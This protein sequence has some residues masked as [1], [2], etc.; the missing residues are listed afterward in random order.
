VGK[1][2]LE[3][4]IARYTD[5]HPSSQDTFT[6][7]W[8]PFYLNRDAPR[9]GVDKREYYV[10]RFGEQRSQMMFQRLAEVGRQEGIN[11]KFGGKTGNTR[12]S[13]RLIQLAKL[14]G[15]ETQ[16]RVVDRLFK[17]YFEEE[18]DITSHD[19][20]V[21]A[22][23]EAG[24]DEN[25]V[26]D[27]MKSDK[28]GPEVDREVLQAQSKFISGVPHFT[29]RGKYHLEGAQDPEAFLEIFNKEQL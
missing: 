8:L 1:R 19:V 14:K 10:K 22:G 4:A 11:F 21:K 15:P 16:D 24:L 2:R 18:Q 7:T 25:T 23:V 5:S 6:T 9:K 17:A 13:H 12:D 29:I 3:R 26:R 20:L 27:W 28:G